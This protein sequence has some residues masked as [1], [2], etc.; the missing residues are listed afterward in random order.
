MES[1]KFYAPTKVVFGVDSIKELSK[2]CTLLNAKKI[3]ILYGSNRI[4]KNGL[5]DTIKAQLDDASI[6]YCCFSGIKANPTLAKAEEGVVVAKEYN[7]DLLLAIGGGSVIDTAKAISVGGANDV[8]LWD[9]WCGIK[10]F[11]KTIPVACVLTIPAAGSEMSDS[12]VLTNE[13]IKQKRGLSSN[14]YRCKFAI[15]DPTYALTL[16][17]KQIACGVTDII[18][19]TLERYFYPKEYQHNSMTDEIAEA[20]IRNTIKFGKRVYENPNDLE[21]M[22]E[23]MWAGSLSHN[24]ITGLGGKKD[25]SV[26][27]FGHEIS[28][29]FDI[30]HGESLSAVWASWARYVMDTDVDRFA[31]FAQYVW[32]INKDGAD[33]AREGIDMMEE[34]F[35][36]IEM[37]ICIPNLSCGI[38]DKETLD[39]LALNCSRNDTRKIGVFRPLSLEEIKEVYYLANIMHN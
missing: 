6:D 36:S 13:E 24:D 14:L 21:A 4:E 7:P 8:K 18:M 12:A 35:K 37:P 23:V 3:M 28:A 19:H 32:G 29:M 15:M 30:T 25:F 10:K 17:K 11:N 2:E 5:L 22:S 38:L 31:H 27:Q 16:P 39:K 9:V 20:L 34:F 33:A 26:H 1:F